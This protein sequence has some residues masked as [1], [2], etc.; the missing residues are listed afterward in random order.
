[1]SSE[2]ILA[3]SNNPIIEEKKMEEPKRGKTR[4]RPEKGFLIIDFYEDRNKFRW[5]FPL[6]T[7]LLFIFVVFT[8]IVSTTEERKEPSKVKID[9]EPANYQIFGH[10]KSNIRD[11]GITVLDKFDVTMIIYIY[12]YISEIGSGVWDQYN[13]SSCFLHCHR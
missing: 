4:L 3:I 8:I 10:Y 11:P 1:M 6:A 9:I 2:S 7:L 12:I 5:I 13:N